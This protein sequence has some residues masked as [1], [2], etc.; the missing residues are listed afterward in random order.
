MKRILV[1]A[2]LGAVPLVAGAGREAPPLPCGDIA[3]MAYQIARAR[4]NG[5]P[6]AQVAQYAPQ[7]APSWTPLI[8][9]TAILVYSR[10]D[11]SP[12]DLRSL[13]QRRCRET[14]VE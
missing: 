12:S 5:V 14:N 7:I 6:Q 13:T 4:D 3:D 10:T 9:S 8:A 11:L 2:L 1:A